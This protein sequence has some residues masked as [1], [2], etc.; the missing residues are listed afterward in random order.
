[1]P[2]KII[3]PVVLVLSLSLLLSSCSFITI[4][5][6]GEGGE[7]RRDETVENTIKYISPKDYTPTARE[8]LRGVKKFRSSATSPSPVRTPPISIPRR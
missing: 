4:N 7:E 5:K 8:K 3:L 6:P 1:M 2:K